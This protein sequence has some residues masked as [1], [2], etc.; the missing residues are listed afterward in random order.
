MDVDTILT[1]SPEQVSCDLMG[2]AV[3][4]NLDSGIYFGLDPVGA[5]VW[6]L[7]QQPRAVGEV[8]DT[9]MDEY[10]VDRARCEKDVVNLLS[11][12]AEHGLV[13]V[14]DAPAT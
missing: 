10:E 1:A 14:G 5:R 9:I 13:S 8:C 12:M 4:L 2:E 7:I 3:M 6:E 11:E